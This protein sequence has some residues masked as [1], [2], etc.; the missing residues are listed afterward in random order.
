MDL[1]AL[2]K[3]RRSIRK[4]KSKSLSRESLLNLIEA[5]CFAHSIC[6]RQRLHFW[7]ITDPQIVDVVIS[8]HVL[9]VLMTV[10]LD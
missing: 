10:I 6:N 4:F 2:I 9:V 8:I 7:I 3:K 1:L 5:A